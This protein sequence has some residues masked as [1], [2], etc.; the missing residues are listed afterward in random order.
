M[1]VRSKIINNSRVV[2]R[3]DNIFWR[4]AAELRQKKARQYLKNFGIIELLQ[5]QVST[6]IAPQFYDLYNLHQ[7]ICRFK[8][9]ICLEFGV[10]FSTIVIAH[11]LSV[12]GFGKVY[13]V[14]SNQYWLDNTLKKIPANLAPYT[15]LNFSEATIDIYNG[16]LCHFYTELPNIV[17]D[18]IYLD[19]PDANDVK[20]SFRGLR[21]GEMIGQKK[22][23]PSVAADILLYESTLRIST[24]FSMIVDGRSVNIDFLIRHLRRNYHVLVDR[25]LQYALFKLDYPFF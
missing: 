17:P 8:P 4:Y 12:N 22:E 7:H 10:G 9:S 13:T 16:S 24:G 20:N 2:L 5:S 21:F 18:F 23:R 15:E 11:A 25:V 19:G 14:D 1:F 6:E 3:P